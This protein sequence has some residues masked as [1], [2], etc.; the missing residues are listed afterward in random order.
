MPS[1]YL[2][3][4]RI[5]GE[6][7]EMLAGYRRSAETMSEVGRDHGLLVHA[8]ASADD[9]LVIVNLW[10]SRDASEDAARD[11]RRQRVAADHRLDLRE[12]RR[13]HSAV[14]DWHGAGASGDDAV[15]R[16]ARWS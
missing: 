1:A 3:I 12:V 9:G 11:P 8:A 6:P 13:D 15:S 7:G 4:T 16:S 2:T 10:P 5:S 14:A